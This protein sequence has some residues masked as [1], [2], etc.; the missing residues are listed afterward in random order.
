MPFDA[1]AILGKL[2]WDMGE[3]R[4]A[5]AAAPREAGEAAGGVEGRFEAMR[6]AAAE[7]FS[8]MAG[9]AGAAFRGLSETLGEVAGPG[10]ARFAEQVGEALGSFGQAVPQALFAAA[11]NPVLGGLQ[12]IGAAA[13]SMTSVVTASVGGVVSAVESVGAAFHE[14]GLAAERLG[15]GV[16]W[17]SRLAAVGQT[18]GV[19][20]EALGNGLRVLEQRAELAGEG[21]EAAVRGFER[22]GIS[23]DQAAGLMDRP[24][25]LFD[26]VRQRMEALD[27]PA[28]RIEAAFGV[29]GRAGAAMVPIL[30]TSGEE[31]DKVADRVARLGGVVSEQDAGL[32]RSLGEL[33]AYFHA[34][35]D[36][37]QRAVA[38]PVLEYLQAHLEEVE[39]KIEAAAGAIEGAI[40]TAMQ[41]IGEQ[42]QA[43]WPYL[44]DVASTLAGDFGPAVLA[45][46]PLLAA[47]WVDVVAVV[48]R[49]YDVFVGLKPVLAEVGDWVKTVI[50][51]ATEALQAIGK[52]VDWVNG[53][54]SGSGG[55]SPA[56]AAAVAPVAESISSSAA[57]VRTPAPA[58]ARDPTEDEVGDYEHEGPAPKAKRGGGGGSPTVNVTVNAAGLDPDLVARAAANKIRPAV[59]RLRDDADRRYAAAGGSGERN[60]DAMLGGTP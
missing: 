23:A 30:T 36:G 40:G 13:E 5:M 21:N 6:E 33:E 14:T 9:V 34:A 3:F 32:G 28:K 57:T 46:G 7:T 2:Q 52:V 29:M 18:A 38:R 1:G 26:L 39:P 15:V 58:E 25:E 54:S 50:G 56:V 53:G 43:A 27:S 16:E 45:V 35:F 42:A 51:W 11:V 24:Q 12:L 60:L 20:L 37:I 59:Q 31:F 44:K 10:V 48:R 8:A 19:G 47:G 22:L 55:G 17:M 41:W 4:A 49:A